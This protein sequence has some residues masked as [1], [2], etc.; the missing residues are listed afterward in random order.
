M[1]VLL[2]NLLLSQEFEQFLGFFSLSIEVEEEIVNGLILRLCLFNAAIANVFQCIIHCISLNVH[3]RW[4]ELA[5]VDFAEL[6][7]LQHFQRLLRNLLDQHA[8]IPDHN[9]VTSVLINYF[10]QFLQ[11]LPIILLIDIVNYDC[12]VGFDILSKLY[13]L[14]NLSMALQYLEYRV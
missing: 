1:T 2:S 6:R 10:S 4:Y 14:L 13:A 9:V 12:F 8:R 7:S 11:C 3:K 5:H